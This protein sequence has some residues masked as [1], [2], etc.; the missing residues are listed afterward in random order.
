MACIIYASTTS[1]CVITLIYLTVTDSNRPD[2][3]GIKLRKKEAEH[4][5]RTNKKIGVLNTV[6][7]YI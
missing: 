6:Y 2:L 7:Y 1:C 3:D 4:I 5:E